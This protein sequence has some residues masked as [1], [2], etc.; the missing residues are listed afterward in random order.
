MIHWQLY[1]K[2]ASMPTHFALLIDVLKKHS[3]QIDSTTHEK[4]ESNDVLAVL[5]NDLKSM[6]FKVESGKRAE[7]RVRVPVLF[8]KDGKVEKSFA[9]DAFHEE[10]STVLEVEA[11]RGF[12]NY[13][14][15]KDFFEA[16]SMQGVNYLAIAMSNVYIRAMILKER[17]L[18]L[19][20]YTSVDVCQFLS[21]VC[22]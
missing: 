14:F 9:V 1:P 22:S 2:S 11:G 15:L 6:G 12:I 10:T 8:G 21:R 19:T 17:T 5:R 4:L 7:E 20:H 13:Q 3:T 16:C 18:F